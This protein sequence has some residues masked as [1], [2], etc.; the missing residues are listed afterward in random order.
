MVL[1]RNLKIWQKTAS[2]SSQTRWRKPSKLDREIFPPHKQRKPE[3]DNK[4][5]PTRDKTKPPRQK[6]QP[7]YV[8]PG[9]KKTLTRRPDWTVDDPESF[10]TVNRG[11][12]RTGGEGEEED[13]GPRLQRGE[14][15]NITPG[16]KPSGTR[17]GVLAQEEGERRRKRPPP[18]L[19]A[20]KQ[21]GRRNGLLQETKNTRRKTK[22]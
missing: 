16:K 1:L 10:S 6:D 13:L 11:S 20:P 8:T 3:T 19:P 17:A 7:R 15:S 14:S 5:T 22:Q 12:R 18:R 4:K 21:R 2:T 9:P